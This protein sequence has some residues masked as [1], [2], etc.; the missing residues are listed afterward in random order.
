MMQRLPILVLVLPLIAAGCSGCQRCSVE[1]ATAEDAARAPEISDG[2]WRELPGAVPM[3]PELRRRILASVDDSPSDRDGRAPDYHNRLALERSPYLLQHAG[4]PVNWYPWGDEAFAAAR[5]LDRPILLSIGYATCHWCHV[6]E[7]ESFSDPEIAEVINRHFVAIKVDREERP[8]VDAHF[9]SVLLALTG[10][11]GWPT[12]VIM[13]PEAQPFFAA[14]YIPPRA[15]ARGVRRGLVEILSNLAREYR[16]DH[17]QVVARAERV[18]RAAARRALGGERGDLPGPDII[19]AAVARYVASYDSINGGFGAA[20]R[21]PQPAA[22]AFL[23]GQAECRRDPELLAIVTRTLESMAD[24]GIYDH[25]GGGFHRYSTDARWLVPH[26]EKMLYDQAQLVRIYLDAYQATGR[27]RFARVA[28]ETLDFV[29]REL[30][31]PEG[32]F[33]AG[34]DADSEG[35]EGSYYTWTPDEVTEALDWETTPLALTRYGVTDR[36]HLEERSVLHIAS[37]LEETGAAVGLSVQEVEEALEAARSGLL[38]A[39]AQRPPPPTD[40]LIITS[41]NGLMIGALAR[42][43]MVLGEPEHAQSAERAAGMI[44]DRMWSEETGLSRNRRE[45]HSWGRA[46]LNDYAFVIWG[47]LQLFQATGTPRWLER[48]IALEGEM[49]RVFSD[50][51]GHYVLAQPDHEPRLPARRPAHDGPL[52][53]GASV[54]AESLL[55]LAELTG[56]ARYRER[57]IRLLRA[58]SSAL[59]SRPTSLTHM[60]QSLFLLR[61]AMIEVVLVSPREGGDPEP[62]HAVLRSLY[63]PGSVTFSVREGEEIEALSRLTQLVRHRG[64]RNDRTT[65]YVCM[66]GSCRFPTTDLSVFRQQLAEAR[67]SVECRSQ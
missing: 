2:R 21:F 47:L 39:R 27:E 66:G 3:T 8:D 23:L 60:L 28:A 20:P 50:E 29:S 25:I 22:L 7:E 37:S 34:L 30:T 57:A 18:S 44:L 48:A 33:Y 56:E 6:M 67:G 5:E 46:V 62:F 31:S 12:T 42:A 14:T 13:T 65:A 10:S 11:G 38:A 24:G 45:G 53:S 9:M 40:D 49:E 32:G 1:G 52:P 61:S 54:A 51:N 64:A 55:L 19:D 15:G 4:N 17:E 63:L 35:Q 43:S 26:F 16:S 58:Y 59:T 36:G 41:W